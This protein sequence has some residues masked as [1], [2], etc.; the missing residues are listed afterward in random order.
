MY[1]Q[2]CLLVELAS[3]CVMGTGEGV[4]GTERYVSS[5]LPPCLPGFATCHQTTITA[6]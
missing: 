5:L 6:T 3:L 2:T 1:R 4:K